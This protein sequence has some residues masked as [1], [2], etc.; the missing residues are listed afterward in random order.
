MRHGRLLAEDSPSRLLD[1]YGH[2]SLEDVFLDLCLKED[3]G[4]DKEEEEEANRQ[5]LTVI[6]KPDMYSRY[7]FQQHIYVQLLRP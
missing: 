4:K 7:Q 5:D 1:I 3:M 2:A 6:S